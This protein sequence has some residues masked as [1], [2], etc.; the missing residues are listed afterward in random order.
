MDVP[1]CVALVNGGVLCL[2]GRLKLLM[3]VSSAKMESEGTQSIIYTVLFSLFPSS[4]AILASLWQG[5][6]QLSW[7]W[8][9][10]Q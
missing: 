2:L 5:I 1:R 9:T 8:R 3:L 10:F 4:S 6:V 7:P